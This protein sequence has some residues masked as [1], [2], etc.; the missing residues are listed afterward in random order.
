MKM[1]TLICKK[2]NSPT[3]ITL[4]ESFETELKVLTTWSEVCKFFV[5]INWKLFSCLLRLLFL[6]NES[7]NL[8]G[9]YS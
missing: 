7:I 3:G 8:F 6:L 5:F 9:K 4:V 1:K 2:S